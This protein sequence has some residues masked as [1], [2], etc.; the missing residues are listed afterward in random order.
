VRS[1]GSAVKLPVLTSA[2]LHSSHCDI[3][4]LIH[5]RMRGAPVVRGV[6]P[7]HGAVFDVVLDPLVF[8]IVPS[9]TLYLVPALAVVAGLGAIVGVWLLTNPASPL[10]DDYIANLPD[11]KDEAGTDSEEAEL[12]LDSAATSEQAIAA[13]RAADAA[14]VALRVATWSADRRAQTPRRRR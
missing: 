14:L 7:V 5:A 3:V 12:V 1:V 2:E 13:D 4:V 11:V 6:S 8:G 10:H 9:A